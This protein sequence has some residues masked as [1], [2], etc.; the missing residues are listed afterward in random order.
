MSR[1]KVSCGFSMLQ[2]TVVKSLF[3]IVYYLKTIF[4]SVSLRYLLVYSKEYNLYFDKSAIKTYLISIKMWSISVQKHI[5]FTC[6][7]G[8]TNSPPEVVRA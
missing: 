7:K 6:L 5:S 2:I 4:F 1:I 3:V 8:R